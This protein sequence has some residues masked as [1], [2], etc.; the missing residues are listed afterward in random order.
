MTASILVT[1]ATGFVGQHVLRR[2]HKEG[3]AVHGISQHGGRVDD[4]SVDAV[5]LTDDHA[6][7]FWAQGKCFDAMIHLAASIPNQLVGPEAEKSFRANVAS[8]LNVLNLA[9][10]GASHLIYASS[11]TVYG[12]RPR[13][14]LPLAESSVLMPDNLY[15]LSKHVSEQLCEQISSGGFPCAILRISAPYGEG[16]RRRTVMNIFLDAARAGRDLAL[17]GSGMRTQDFTH[18]T[19]VVEFIWLSWCR[20]AQGAFNV[21][22]GNP[23]SMRMLAEHVLAVVPGTSSQIVYADKPDPQDEYRASLSIARASEQLGWQAKVDLKAGLIDLLQEKQGDA[24]A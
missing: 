21:A 1:G 22:N 8:T 9:R 11:S 2:F 17:Y 24:G 4:L 7:A 20:R 19:D 6:V 23:V 18:I 15:S 12:T 16:N 13:R 14:D 10:E 3:I 5:D